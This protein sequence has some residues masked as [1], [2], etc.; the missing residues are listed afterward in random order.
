MLG[1]SGP[2]EQMSHV[3]PVSSFGWA[4]RWLGFEAQ[5]AADELGLS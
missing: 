5:P 2:V 4:V 1:C 3:L